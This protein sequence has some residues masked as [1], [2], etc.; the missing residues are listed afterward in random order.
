[1]VFEMSWLLTLSLFLSFFLSLFL[2]LSFFLSLTSSIHLI[3]EGAEDYCCTWSHSS[4][5]HAYARAL[6]LLWDMNQPNEETSTWQQTTLTIYTHPCQRQD[7]NP[8]SQQARGCRPTPCT[9][10]GVRCSLK[11]SRNVRSGYFH[12]LPYLRQVFGQKMDRF[13]TNHLFIACRRL[14]L[15]GLF[16]DSGSNSVNIKLIGRMINEWTWTW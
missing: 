8:Q 14:L 12:L 2:F 1:M 11:R 10:I 9:G 3:I 13:W 6:G 5:T 4:D 16:N 15:Y 7:S